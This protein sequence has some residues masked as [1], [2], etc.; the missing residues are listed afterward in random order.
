MINGFRWLG[1]FEGLSFLILLLIAMPLK[2][3]WGEPSAVKL[4]GMAHGV[5]FLLYLFS[6]NFVAQQLDWS[7]K[8]WA[9]SYV[10]AVIPLGTFWF[11]KKHLPE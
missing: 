5:L 1:R 9:L 2:Y 11:E 8:V 10:A 4:V 6:A 7:K 3:I